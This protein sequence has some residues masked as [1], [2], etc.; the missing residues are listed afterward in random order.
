[1]VYAE[2]YAAE[3]R[4]QAVQVKP[5]TAFDAINCAAEQLA[6]LQGQAEALAVRM[7]GAGF[8]EPTAESG[9]KAAP[10]CVFAGLGQIADGMTT[11][12]QRIRNALG[13]IE[14]QLP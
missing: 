2:T 9:A 8:Q 4:N 7:V 5:R 3:A 13:A 12:I 10:D 11:R 6:D 1:M 14:R